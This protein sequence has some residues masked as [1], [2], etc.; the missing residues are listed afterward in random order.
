MRVLLR[1]TAGRARNGVTI[2]PTLSRSRRRRLIMPATACPRRSSGVARPSAHH[3]GSKK[4]HQIQ[5]ATGRNTTST[6]RA[7]AGS[8]GTKP[9]G[10]ADASAPPAPRRHGQGCMASGQRRDAKRLRAALLAAGRGSGLRHRGGAAAPSHPTAARLARR[11]APG[12]RRG[13][14]LP[15]RE[16][17]QKLKQFALIEELG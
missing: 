16:W 9:A 14:R 8:G 6:R 11:G 1:S 3:P 7:G 12:V 17:P 2:T 15:R 5:P 4:A 10:S 13:L